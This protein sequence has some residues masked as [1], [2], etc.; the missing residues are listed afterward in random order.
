MMKVLSKRSQIIPI[1][2]QH[3]YKIQLEMSI[4]HIPERIYV[5]SLLRRHCE[6][7]SDTILELKMYFR[8]I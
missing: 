7:F 1:K 3:S 4:H 8:I 2:R 5:P 6:V